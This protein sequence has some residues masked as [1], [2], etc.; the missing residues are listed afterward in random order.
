[1]P[2]QRLLGKWKLSQNKTERARNGV[3]EGLA[4]LNTPESLAMKALVEEV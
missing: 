2:I 4:E 3:I 1:M